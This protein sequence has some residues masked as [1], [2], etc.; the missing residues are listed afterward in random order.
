MIIRVFLIIPWKLGFAGPLTGPCCNKKDVGNL[1]YTLVSSE[2]TSIASTYGCK[3]NCVYEQDDLPGSKFCFAVGD[4]LTACK[5]S[6]EENTSLFTESPEENTSLLTESP[7]GPCDN[8]PCSQG[9]I[10]LHT[11]DNLN[12]YKIPYA[13][14]TKLVARATASRC[15]EEGM[16]AVCPKPSGCYLNSDQCMVTPLADGQC[17]KYGFLDTLGQKICNTSHAPDCPALERLTV[18]RH[19]YPHGDAVI[20][21]NSDNYLHTEVNGGNPIIAGTEE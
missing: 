8:V 18:F 13:E 1:S 4:L 3:S 5:E 2:D 11:E 9:R 20:P 12:Y 7:E 16:K 15:E 6:P 14:G 19:G 10:L 21:A 17:E